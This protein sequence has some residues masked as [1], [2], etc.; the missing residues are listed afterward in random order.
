MKRITEKFEETSSKR[1]SFEK[2]NYL[3]RKTLLAFTKTDRMNPEL[4]LGDK[5]LNIKNNETDSHALLFLNNK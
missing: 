5:G 2:L 1:K 3:T 4:K